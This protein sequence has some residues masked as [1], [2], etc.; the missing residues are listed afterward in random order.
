MCDT[1]ILVSKLD[2]ATSKQTMFKV[3]AFADGTQLISNHT[4]RYVYV[5]YQLGDQM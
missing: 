4:Q 5:H 3:T 2:R 1:V